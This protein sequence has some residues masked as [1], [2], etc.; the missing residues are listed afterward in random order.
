M[1]VQRNDMNRRLIANRDRAMARS[2]VGDMS[3]LSDRRK[4]VRE[5]DGRALS[6]RGALVSALVWLLGTAW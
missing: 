5:R 6:L 2:L 3:T 4:P 1:T